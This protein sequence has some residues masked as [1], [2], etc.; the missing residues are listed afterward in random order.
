MLLGCLLAA[1]GISTQ[2]GET[3]DT[4]A[5]I[6]VVTTSS[7]LY[8]EVDGDSSDELWQALAGSANP[9]TTGHAAGLRHLGDS[10][11]DYRYR[12][13]SSRDR[14]AGYCRVSTARVELHYT[15]MLPALA[16]EWS[17]PDR[18]RQQWQA[19]QTAVADHEAVHVDIYRSLER[20]IPAAIRGL[21]AMPCD[22]LAARVDAAIRDT[23][24]NAQLASARFDTEAGSV[25]QVASM[26]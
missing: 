14:S 11:L 6:E 16:D 1:G 5:G 21:G 20:E 17:K 22:R 18:L 25:M 24:A 2:A 23:A 12:F 10:R 9:L 13:E 4:G 15:T 19:M 26:D 7:T 8:Y 3:S